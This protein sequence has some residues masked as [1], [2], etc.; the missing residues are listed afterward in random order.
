M[1]KQS[2]CFFNK[3]S[4]KEIIPKKNIIDSKK[5]P[6]FFNR[7]NESIRSSIFLS[8]N[9]RNKNLKNLELNYSAWYR[10]KI[11]TWYNGIHEIYNGHSKNLKNSFD[12]AH[13]KNKWSSNQNVS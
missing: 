7:R 10:E 11:D 12:K 5:I 8:K 9:L 3:K 4:L 13:K 6:T 2:K 1:I